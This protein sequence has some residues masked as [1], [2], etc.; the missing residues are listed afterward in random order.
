MTELE[1]I[2][3]SAI[4]LDRVRTPSDHF[5][6]FMEVVMPDNALEPQFAYWEP[7]SEERYIRIFMSHRWG[8]D[9]DLY[10]QVLGQ[11][12]S[13]GHSIDDVS[14]SERQQ[15]AGPRGGDVPDL[16][17]QA[18][19][20]ARIFTSDIVIVA[21][22][23]GIT[24]S[25]WVMWELRIAAIGY[26]VPILFLDFDNQ[27]RRAAI[28]AEITALG[29]EPGVC[30]PVVTEIVP[31]VLELVGGRPKW[32]VRLQEHDP[33][34]RFRGPPLLGGISRKLPYRAALPEVSAS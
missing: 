6:K 5:K 30:Q 1:Q 2:Q 18:E 13:Q 32:G 22:R 10:G 7:G 28:V 16:N 27:Q 33:N 19:V 17:V 8:Q 11:L 25:D 26:G 20:A 24:R 12:R 29:L 14:L 3:E 31:R 23:P 34:L 21:S 4:L 15:I 9:R